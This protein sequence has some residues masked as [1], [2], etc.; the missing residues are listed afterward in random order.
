MAP[1]RALLPAALLALALSP[2]PAAALPCIADCPAG[3]F[4]ASAGCGRGAGASCLPCPAGTFSSAAGRGGCRMCRRCEGLFQYLKACS[5]TR[6]AECTCKEGYRCGGDGCAYCARSCGVGQES[7]RS[8]CQTCRYGTFNDRPNGSCKNWTMCSG[9]QVLE[10][11]TPAK[12]VICKHPSVNPTLVTT[13]P[14]TSHEIPFSITVPGKEDVQTDMIR[15]SLAVAGLSCLMFLLPLCI[16][17]SVWHKKKLPAVFKKMHTLEQSVQEDDAC[18]C[19]FP[20]EEQGE[21]QDPG[22]S[23]ESR[24]LLVN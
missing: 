17:F 8:G 18:S 19:H 21:Y 3:T 20:E 14:T 9:N 7:T 6:D 5:P 16:C 12:D 23:T 2:G 15:I 1:G 22:K 13:L 24:D 10:P 11:G 4:A